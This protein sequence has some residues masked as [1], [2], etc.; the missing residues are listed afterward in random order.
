MQADGLTA[1][2]ATPNNQTAHGAGGLSAI[3]R[4]IMRYHE[5]SHRHMRGAGGTK[6]ANAPKVKALENGADAR[7]AEWGG[8]ERTPCT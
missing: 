6:N 2:N 3:R 7:L 1:P 4:G 5:Y 8:D